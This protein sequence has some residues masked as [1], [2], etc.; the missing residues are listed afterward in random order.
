MIFYDLYLHVIETIIGN[1]RKAK[2]KVYYWPPSKIFKFDGDGFYNIFWTVY[3]G[4][5]FILILIYLL[6]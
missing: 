6:I 2:K 4:I 5:A 1:W 3:W